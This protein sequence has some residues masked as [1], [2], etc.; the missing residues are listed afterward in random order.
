MLRQHSRRLALTVALSAVAGQAYAFGLG[1]IR[2]QSYIGQPLRAEIGIT[3]ITPDESGSLK[4]QVASPGAFQAAKLQYNDVLSGVQITLQHRPDGTAYLLVVSHRPVSEP[5]LDLLIS[6]QWSNGQ[7]S[8]DYTL[9]LDPAPKS[10]L[11]AAAPQISVQTAPQPAAAPGVAKAPAP[12]P[13]ARPSTKAPMPAPQ[14]GGTYEVHKGDTLSKIARDTA[15]P[16][17]SL[18][19]MLTALYRNNTSAFINDNMNL[20]K[21]GAVLHLPTAEQAAGVSPAEARRF[22]IAQSHSFSAYRE[23]LAQVVGEAKPEAAQAQRESG[24]KVQAKVEEPGAAT[25]PAQSALKLSKAEPKGASQAQMIA[26][27]KQL[28]ADSAKI[29]QLQKNIEALKSAAKEAAA[30]AQHEASTGQ[31]AV[32]AAASKAASALTVPVA[33]P[34]APS[35]P[36]K[37]AEEAPPTHLASAAAASTASQAGAAAPAQHE[38]SKPAPVAKPAPVKPKAEEGNFISDLLASPLLL[39]VGGIVVVLL[40]LLALLAQ[41]RKKAKSQRDVSV[42]DSRMSVADSF[43]GGTGGERVDTRNSSIGSTFSSS[44]IDTNDVDPVAEADVYLAYGRDL[45]AEEILKEAVKANPDRNAARL[46]LLEIYAKRKDSRSF[47]VGAAELFAL[48]QGVGEDWQKAQELGRN[49]DPIN[50]LYHNTVPPSTLGVPSTVPQTEFPAATPTALAA[51]TPATLPSTEMMSHVQPD[52]AAKA[53]PEVLDLDLN[54][55]LSGD[56]PATAAPAVESRE[57]DAPVTMTPVSEAPAQ[58][59]APELPPTLPETSPATTS[60]LEQDFL[61]SG[62]DF[63]VPS[64]FGASRQPEAAPMDLPELPQTPAAPAVSG[65]AADAPLEFDL[66]SISLDGESAAKPVE[67]QISSLPQVEDSSFADSQP[68]DTRFELAAESIAIGDLES[69]RNLLEELKAEGEESVRARAQEM[70][71]KIGR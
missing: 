8:R 66:S 23:R 48:T 63:S 11:T 18:E 54:L 26:D 37:A 16:T 9:L 3:Q 2:I 21:A 58:P 44:Q 49:L 28:S 41:R 27:Q 4:V 70:L 62:L 15:V 55:P 68:L 46:K 60:S 69:A 36:E 34:V 47:E 1:P 24:G 59:A 40:L 14:A 7:L 57:V 32:V 39:P 61:S 31:A 22:V 6:A 50:P 13:T 17:V 65:G 42:F 67:E 35:A 71:D 10:S 38:A 45:Q 5:F 29:A 19:Q 33:A 64:Q 51:L 52:A 53:L 43:F 30:P 20:L 56:E 12:A 25:A